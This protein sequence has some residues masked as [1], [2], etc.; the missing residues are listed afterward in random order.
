MVERELRGLGVSPGVRMGKAFIYKPIRMT[1]SGKKTTENVSFEIQRLQQ[2]KVKC[3]KELESLI[4]LAQRTVGEE[5]A[6]IL[7]GQVSMLQDPAFYP[8]IENLIVT[9]ERTAESAICQ[10]VEQVAGL[11]ESMDS[12]YMRERGPMCVI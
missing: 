3:Q 11:F 7:K 5:K 9:E 8:P 12:E 1:D 10:V 2:A 4:E 6:A